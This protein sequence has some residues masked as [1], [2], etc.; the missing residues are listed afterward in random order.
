MLIL[1]TDLEKV[2]LEGIQKRKNKITKVFKGRFYC[3]IMAKIILIAEDDGMI[4]DMEK[5]VLEDK[6]YIVI[7][8]A[9]GQA[10]FEAYQKSREDNAAVDL[11]LTDREMPNL[12]GYGLISKVREINKEIP[13]I[14]LSGGMKAEDEQRAHDLGASYCMNK[15]FKFSE[16]V[17]KV[18]ELTGEQ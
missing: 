13:I 7:P 18:R 8:T 11:I 3:F 2:C 4:L 12:D 17:N 9:D 5:G 10:A 6:G 14:M 15:P 16:L 1:Q